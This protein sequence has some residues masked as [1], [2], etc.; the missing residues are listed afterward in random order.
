MHYF[1]YTTPQAVRF[2]VLF[3]PMY[4]GGST[5][6]AQEGPGRALRINPGFTQLTHPPFTPGQT[7]PCSFQGRNRTI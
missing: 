7:Y 3:G 6:Q 4:M 5:A 1:K 2:K